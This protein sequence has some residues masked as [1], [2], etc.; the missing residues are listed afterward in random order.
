MTVFEMVRNSL[1]AGFGVQ[2]KVKEFVDDLVKKGE[3]SDSQG[4]K[5]IK[6]WSDKADRSSKEISKTFS[7]VVAKAVERMNLATKADIEKLTKKIHLL[8]GRVKKL[9]GIGE[10]SPE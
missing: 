9:E 6:E 3:L 8:N 2:E 1:L 10:D 4:A 7:D 5:L